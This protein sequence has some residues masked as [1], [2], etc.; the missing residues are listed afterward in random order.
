[1]KKGFSY[2]VAT[3]GKEIN[4]RLSSLLETIEK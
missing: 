2:F 4:K 3:I 1:M